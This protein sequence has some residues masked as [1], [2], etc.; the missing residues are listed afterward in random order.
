METG[1]VFMIS[2][3][4]KEASRQNNRVLI[5]PV[6]LLMHPAFDEKEV[7]SWLVITTSVF[8]ST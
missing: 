3:L 1:Y 2:F 5:H 8:L 7:L 4:R 6:V